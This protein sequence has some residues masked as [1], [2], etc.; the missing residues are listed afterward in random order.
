MLLSCHY[1]YE[2]QPGDVMWF[3]PEKLEPMLGR[4]SRR[5][6]SCKSLVRPGTLAACIVR[7]KV[8]KT[9]I[10]LSIYGEDCYDSGVPRAS[11]YVCQDCSNIFFFLQ[12]FHYV[13]DLREDLRE[14]AKEHAELVK[15][16]QAGCL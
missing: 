8:P 10:E 13:I 15:A 3:E 12:S 5:C 6:R 1:D 11:H 14:L 16:G 7:Y 2:P 9:D 4:R